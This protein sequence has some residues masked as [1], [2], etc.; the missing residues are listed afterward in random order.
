MSAR[1][2]ASAVTGH[3]DRQEPR[4]CETRSPLGRLAEAVARLVRSWWRV[5]R[6]RV[7]PGEGK[8]LHLQPGALITI[9]DQRA[10]I[11]GRSTPTGDEVIYDCRT[12]DATAQLVVRLCRR[13]HGLQVE[14]VEQGRSRAVAETD[15]IV[16]RR[17]GRV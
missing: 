8:L 2:G 14:W 11:V 3:I 16:W 7:S 10:E 1:K 4:A 5:D 13:S 17:S 15:V 6:I 12:G 9:D